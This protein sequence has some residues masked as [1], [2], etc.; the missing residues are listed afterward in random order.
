MQ[1]EH[2][3]HHAAVTVHEQSLSG[4]MKQMIADKSLRWT[5]L[6]H[7]NTMAMK[8]L[9]HSMSDGM[10]HRVKEYTRIRGLQGGDA[11]DDA[12]PEE[13]TNFHKR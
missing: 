2:H 12:C 7:D 5:F 10:V 8:L 9:E 1:I 3:S 4:A 13:P 6:D 11:S